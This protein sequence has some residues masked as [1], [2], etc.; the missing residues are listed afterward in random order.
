MDSHHIQRVI[1]QKAQQPHAPHPTLVPRNVI[2]LTTSWIL[3][4]ITALDSFALS[5]VALEVF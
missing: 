1:V 4:G 5:H 3:V 2:A